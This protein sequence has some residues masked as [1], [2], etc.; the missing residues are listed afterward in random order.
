[1]LF[2]TSVKTCAFNWS[3]KTATP[4][5]TVPSVG[6]PCP[7]ASPWLGSGHGVGGHVPAIPG[8]VGSGS[9]PHHQSLKAHSRRPGARPALRSEALGAVSGWFS[10]WGFL[11][12]LPLQFHF[13]RREPPRS[14]WTRFLREVRISLLRRETAKEGFWTLKLLVLLMF[15][16]LI[17]GFSICKSYVIVLY[18][19]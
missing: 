19:V 17:T 7:P 3:V 4:Y 2:R 16:L 8:Q 10:V 5:P 1:M 12:L 6:A 9:A 14:V 13:H 18:L 11:F 15:E